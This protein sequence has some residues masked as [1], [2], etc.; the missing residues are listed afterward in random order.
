MELKEYLGKSLEVKHIAN[1]DVKFH[2]YG[3]INHVDL[4]HETLTLG[5][6]VIKLSQMFEVNYFLNMTRRGNEFVKV[7]MSSDEIEIPKEVRFNVHTDRKD[8]KDR[9]D[10]SY[11][12]FSE[13]FKYKEFMKKSDGIKKDNPEN[14]FF[15]F[16]QNELLALR[17]SHI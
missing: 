8:R 2:I 17:L 14:D 7:I 10:M 15:E 13:K 5:D 11:E 9:N 3:H 16:T 4:H 6:K 1:G 12:E